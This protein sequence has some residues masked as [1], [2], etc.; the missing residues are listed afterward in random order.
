MRLSGIYQTRDDWVDNH[1]TGEGDAIEGYDEIAGRVQFL[2]E[3]GSAVSALSTCTRA[4]ST[5]PRAC[6]APTSSSRAP[7]TSC[8]ASTDTRSPRRGATTQDLESIGGSR[9]S[10]TTISARVTLHLDHRLR[11][12]R[13]ATAAATS[14][15]ASAPVRAARPCLPGSARAVFIPFPRR[16]GGRHRRP[17]PD[18]AGVPPRIA[19]NERH[20]RLAGGRSTTSTKPGHRQLQLR[21]P[22][23]GVEHDDVWQHAEQPAW[24]VFGIGRATTSPTRSR[25]ARGLR[26]TDDEKD[27]TAERFTSPVGAGPIGPIAVIT[28]E[29]QLSWDLSAHLVRSATTRTSTRASPRAS[30]RRPSRA[31]TRCSATRPSVANSEDDHV[32]RGRHQDEPVRTTAAGSTFAIYKYDDGRPAADGRRRRREFQHARSTPTRRTARASSSTSRPTSPTTSWSRSA[33]AD[34]TPRSTTRISASG[35][36]RR[37]HVP[38]PCTVPAI[39]PSMPRQRHHRRQPLAAV[40]RST[41]ANLTARWGM[42]VGERRV[43][44]LHRLGLPQRDQLLPVRVEGVHRRCAAR[45]RPAASATRGTTASRKSRS[46]GRNI[47]DEIQA[48]GG[49]DFN[50][51]TGFIN[52][53]RRYFVEFRS[54]F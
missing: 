28:D 26:Y 34:T 9:S 50:N 52:E 22:F 5:A 8:R 29:D 44:R 39:P 7:T 2:Y 24:A 10:S 15:A 32:R 49:I 40:A 48:V 21:H 46:I 30:A 35:L 6:S 54:K 38:G 1:F 42:P 43:L 4:A 33:R 47:T 19:A 41:I 16:V 13:R 31:A 25:C 45:G 18:H 20:V 14:T 36:R 17:R 53:P 12:G 3:L 11:D 51:L 27:F 37:L 23:G